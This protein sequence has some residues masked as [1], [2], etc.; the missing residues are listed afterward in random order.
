MINIFDV[1]GK[2]IIA[3]YCSKWSIDADGYGGRVVFVVLDGGAIIELVGND[4]CD[5]GIK[6]VSVSK[7]SLEKYEDTGIVGQ[8]I[9]DIVVSDLWPTA[10]LLLSD[11]SILT[12]GESELRRVGPIRILK[13]S[14]DFRESD[15]SSVQSHNKSGGTD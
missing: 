14:L 11:G 8:T 1:I 10:G 7:D 3:A 12:T 4:E 15:Y 9:C 2:T 13:D 6:Q 5:H